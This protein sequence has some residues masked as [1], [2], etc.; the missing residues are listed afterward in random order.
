MS[1]EPR[2]RSRLRLWEVPW[3]LITVVAA[4]WLLAIASQVSGA[5][6][7]LHHDALVH[8]ELPVWASVGLFVLA[9]QAMIAAMMLP[10]SLP[11]VR[12]YSAAIARR[13]HPTRLLVAFLVGY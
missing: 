5:A 11:L 12:L 4:A 2:V 7:A 8:A 3:P 6:A 13:P 9:W 10:S 1:P